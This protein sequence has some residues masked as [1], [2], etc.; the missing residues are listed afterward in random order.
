MIIEERDL[1]R[2]FQLPPTTY[3]GG[4]ET[5][6]TLR[7]IMKRLEVGLKFILKSGPN[8]SILLVLIAFHMIPLHKLCPHIVTIA[9]LVRA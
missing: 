6:L 7:E 4:T 2:N 8:K 1:D 5:Q 3:I 9:Q